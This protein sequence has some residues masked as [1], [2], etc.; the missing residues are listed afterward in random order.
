MKKTHSKDKVKGFHLASKAIQ[1]CYCLSLVDCLGE[2]PK[3]PEASLLS[4]MLEV[5]SLR[6]V[7]WVG[8]SRRNLAE[9]GKIC[10]L[11]HLKIPGGILQHLLILWVVAIVDPRRRISLALSAMLRL[12]ACP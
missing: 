2:T 5:V 10:A 6:A 1:T 3:I 8:H 4:I 7:H 12:S 11:T 9:P